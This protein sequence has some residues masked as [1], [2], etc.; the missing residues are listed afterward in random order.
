MIRWWVLSLGGA[1][2][3]SVALV[4]SINSVAV[5]VVIVVAVQLV[6]VLGDGTFDGTDTRS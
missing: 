3:A 5:V 1:L 4:C 2:R 6:L